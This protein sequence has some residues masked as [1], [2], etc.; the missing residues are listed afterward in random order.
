MALAIAEVMAL[1]KP[2]GPMIFR[3]AVVFF[4]NAPK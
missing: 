2:G 4:A 3:R 1:F